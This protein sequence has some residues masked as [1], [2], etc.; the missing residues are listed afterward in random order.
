MAAGFD[1]VHIPFRGGPEALTEVLSGRAEF[2]FCP[3][4]TALPYVREGKLL[5]L[6]VSSPKRAPLMPDVPS[7]LEIFPNSDYP[8][9]IGV[10][11]PAKAPRDIV[12][13]L[14]R[15]A[16]ATMQSPSVKE[17]LEALG[18]DPMPLTPTEFDAHVRAEIGS[19][20]ALA[21]AAGVKP[22]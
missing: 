10:F 9:W 16:T 18:M 15:E 22:N 17:R 12:D 5:A 14:H 11:M 7:G 6:A 3:L 20:G 13:K 4:G 8:F 1:A 21:Q 19:T 2:Y